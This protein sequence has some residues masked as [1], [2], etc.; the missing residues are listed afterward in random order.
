MLI[1]Y[2]D[3]DSD[4]REILSNAVKAVDPRVSCKLFES[5]E[6]LLNFLGTS[7]TLPD[8]IFIDINMPKMNGYECAKKVKSIPAFGQS[9]IVMYSTC[10]NP[11]DET[12]FAKLGVKCLIKPSNVN[13]LVQSIRKLIT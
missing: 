11:E 2:A 1:F 3:D 6:E 4:D 8:Y 13:D 7:S 9:Q 5:G 12:E 10:F